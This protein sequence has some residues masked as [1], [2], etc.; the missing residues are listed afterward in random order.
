MGI[1]GSNLQSCLSNSSTVDNKNKIFTF[2][3]PN[4]TRQKGQNQDLWITYQAYIC[5]DIYILSTYRAL[6]AMV[7]TSYGAKKPKD[8][9]SRF[10]TPQSTLTN[11]KLASNTKDL[12]KIPPNYKISNWNSRYLILIFQIQH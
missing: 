8:C 11:H 9:S 5:G 7:I 12:L 3:I 6:Q 1:S 4:K 10:W 2:Q